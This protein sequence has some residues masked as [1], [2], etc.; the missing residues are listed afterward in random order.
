MRAVRLDFLVFGYR[1]LS[2]ESAEDRIKCSGALMRMGVPHATS[3][4]LDVLVRERDYLQNTEYIAGQNC[5]V[6]E[7]AKGVI[8]ALR[9]GLKAKLSLAA[10]LVSM[11]LILLAPTVVWDVRVSGCEALSEADVEAALS[12]LGLRVG[13][14][15]RSIDVGKTELRLLDSTPEVGW[16]AINRRGSVA[17]VEIIE[18]SL[19]PEAPDTSLYSNVV[20]T[21]DCVIRDISVTS[22]YAVVE[23]GDVVRRGEVLISG[24]PPAGTA[25]GFCHAEGVV[26]G[27]CDDV[28][29]VEMSRD[30]TLKE[31]VEGAKSG[32]SLKILNFSINI[33][34]IYRNYVGEC[35]IIENNEKCRLFGKYEIPIEIVTEY[36]LPT[37]ES[38]VHLT[39]A[40]L[41]ALA[42]E[43]MREAI[44]VGT[45]GA[46]LLRLSTSGYYTDSGYLMKT[47]VTVI[48]QVGELT[49]IAVE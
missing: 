2:F 26:L 16:I 19:P 20:A 1:S 3:G 42:S 40:E 29:T 49:P 45:R 48:E 30:L 27:E 17:Y 4:A 32:V 11:L 8:P 34:K 13:A 28:F 9:R 38:T 7:Y 22:G 33:F 37:V 43:K 15:W 12:D 6:S 46:E 18:S 39:D 10:A 44:V 14:V 35:A 5:K 36:S 41:V 47:T 23:V 31:Q 24:I 25:G 21:R